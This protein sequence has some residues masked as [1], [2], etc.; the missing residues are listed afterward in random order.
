MSPTYSFL[1]T[2]A[3]IEGPGGSFP[4]SG[5]GVAD[6]GITITMTEDKG[7]LVSGADGTPMHSLHASRTGQCTIRLLK[8]SQAN[9]LMTNLYNYQTQSAAYYG[10]NTIV[11]NDP[12]RGDNIT[13]QFAGFRKMPDVVFAKEGGMIEWSF[14]CGV[15]DH[16][17][18]SG[19][20]VAA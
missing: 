9:A 11:V 14:N 6:E 19:A 13:C 1:D 16:I 4:L 17:L 10:Q 20:G 8:I 12:V 7:T 18:G 3:A 15:I 5:A 2:Q